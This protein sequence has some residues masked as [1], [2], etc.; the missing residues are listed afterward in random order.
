MVS[1]PKYK[2]NIGYSSIKSE[3]AKV[4][5]KNKTAQKQID[6]SKQTLKKHVTQRFINNYKT[7]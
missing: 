2:T 6:K 3:A 5:N 4:W 7:S 1:I